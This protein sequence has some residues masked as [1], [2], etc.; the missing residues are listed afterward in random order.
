MENQKGCSCWPFK[1]K[2][3]NPDETGSRTNSFQRKKP[4]W[5]KLDIPTIQLTPDEPPQAAAPHVGSRVAAVRRSNEAQ[6][7]NE[8]QPVKRVRSVSMPGENPHTHSAAMET[9][10]G[11]LKPPVEKMAVMQSIKRGTADWF[12]VSKDGDGGQRWRRRSLQHCSQLFGGLKAQVTLLSLD[13]LSLSSTDPHPDPDP[14]PRLSPRHHRYGMQRVVD[15]LARG[16]AFRMGDDLDGPG[17]PQ[18]PLTP[19]SASLCSFSSSRS[20]LNRLPRRRKRESVAVM[21]IKAA[22][23]LMKVWFLSVYIYRVENIQ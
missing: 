20:A 1:M 5:L 13:S 15:P 22:A 8:F 23:A 18:M 12:G 11:Y 17:A 6:D 7:K 16:R 4:P 3:E 19:G 10:N 21:S 2:A 9:S 14:T